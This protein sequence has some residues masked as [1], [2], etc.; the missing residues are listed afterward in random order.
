MSNKIPSSQSLTLQFSCSVTE[1]GGS[2][3]AMALIASITAP[4]ELFH[5][6]LIQLLEKPKIPPLKNKIL[7]LILSLYNHT[8]LKK[9][10]RD[11]IETEFNESCA[12]YVIDG[13]EGLGYISENAESIPKVL[14]PPFPN[15]SNGCRAPISSCYWEWKP[16]LN[17]YYEK[18]RC[19]N[20]NAPPV[21]LLPGFGVGSF[22]YKKQLE[23]LGLNFRVWAVDFFGQGM[24]LPMEDPALLPMEEDIFEGKAF[25]WGFGDKAEPWANEI[26]YFVDRWKDQ[27]RFFI[28]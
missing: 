24:S 25:T 17:V 26:V 3:Q 2:V 1:E 6:D 18:Y 21:L 22:H 9:I 8:R 5:L 10:P 14:I 20:I 11:L 15:E 4:S 16:K 13:E 23:D 19:G 28:E 7:A 27:V 12:G